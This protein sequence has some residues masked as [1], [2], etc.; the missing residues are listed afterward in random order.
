MVSGRAAFP[1]GLPP[2]LLEA[3]V[4]PRPS[5]EG[6]ESDQSGRGCTCKDDAT[7]TCWTPRHR[8]KQS[9]GR[10]PES[11]PPAIIRGEPIS[12]PAA[13]V[14]NAHTGS[15]RPVL[16]KPP[17][18]RAV[19]PFRSSR[20]P[21][22]AHP[23]NRSATHGQSF[24]SPYGRAYEYNHEAGPANERQAY[25][26]SPY[27]PSGSDSVSSVALQ[28]GP[29]GVW[30][31]SNV[32]LMTGSPP[33]SN[34]C[35]CG[36]TCA[37]PGCLQHNGP[38]VDPSASCA[39]PATCSACLECNI[40]SLTAF[41][42]PTFPQPHVRRLAEKTGFS[43]C[44]SSQLSSLLPLAPI[45]R[46]PPSARLSKTYATTSLLASLM[47]A[48]TTPAHSRLPSHP[49]LPRNRP[50]AVDG[51]NAPRECVAALPTAAGAVRAV[52]VAVALTRMALDVLSLSRLPGRGHH[53]VAER[54]VGMIARPGRHNLPKHQRSHRA[55]LSPLLRLLLS[56]RTTTT[57]NR[58]PGTRQ[59]P[60]LVA[61]L[62]DLS[63]HS[64]CSLRACSK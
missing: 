13:L 50:V 3:S 46:P 39:N 8:T 26:S 52:R 36:S 38:N 34:L 22:S 43:R 51:A 17:S 16:P 4:T 55:R 56:R 12:E 54:V 30:Q 5:S 11:R 48:G 64:P 25:A 15:N 7:C 53:A 40:L 58:K 35:N 10:T 57:S 60:G 33:S 24:F 9:G 37:C 44:P 49:S 29:V 6:S 19:S 59:P 45:H 23:S 63:N 18:D 1:S 42:P 20:S 2:E 28:N 31:E 27:P 61:R 32:A 62:L 47:E 41:G 21:S 14:I